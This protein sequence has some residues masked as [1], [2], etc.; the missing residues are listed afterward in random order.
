MKIQTTLKTILFFKD[1]ELI[2]QVSYKTK[3][4]AIRHYKHF[5]KNGCTDINTGNVDKDIKVELL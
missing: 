4:D 3:Y 2:R 1:G 5:L